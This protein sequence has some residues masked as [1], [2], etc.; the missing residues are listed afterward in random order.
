MIYSKFD[1]AVRNIQEAD[2]LGDISDQDLQDAF[3]DDL[4]GGSD[5]GDQEQMG[6]GD[7]QF[8]NDPQ[9]D[10]QPEQ[11]QDPNKQGTI[12]YVEGAHLVYKRPHK[13]GGFEELW[14]YSSSDKGNLESF[15]QEEKIRTEILS[16]T[17]ITSDKTATTDGTQY[18]EVM[19]LGNVEL[20][21]IVGLAN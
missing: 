10:M 18:Y 11:P 1:F 9:M 17:D 14:I 16:G 19:N 20:L 21:N 3:G 15:M 8:M 6:M 2:D 7:D 4:G 12:R 13:D 5:T